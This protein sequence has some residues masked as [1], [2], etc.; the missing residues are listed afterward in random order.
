MIIEQASVKDAEEI[1]GLQRLAYMSEAEIYNDYCIPPL[2]QRLD[3]MLIDFDNQVFLKASVDGK[4]V[5]SIKGYMERETCHIGRLI[6]H[7]DYQ[8]RGIGTQLIKEIEHYFEQTKQY[9]LFTGH[10]SDRNLRLYRSLGYV[11][12]ENRVITESLTLIFLRKINGTC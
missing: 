7:P 2:T 3:Q 5:G 6:V 12:F 11:P 10:R 8:N 4:I 1:L 9:Q